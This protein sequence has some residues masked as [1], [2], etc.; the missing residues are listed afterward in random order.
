MEQPEL[1]EQMRTLIAEHLNM[2][3]DA[4]QLDMSV[5]EVTNSLELGTLMFAVEKKFEVT[6]S[7]SAIGRLRI[8]R[9]LATL[10]LE[11]RA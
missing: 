7:N 11:A 3:L 2:P 10:V 6:F 9:D 1:E 8:L 4:I 5:E